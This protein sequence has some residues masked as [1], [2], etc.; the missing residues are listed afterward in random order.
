MGSASHRTALADALGTRGAW[1]DAASVAAPAASIASTFDAPVDTAIAYVAGKLG[2][3]ASFN[4]T[5]SKI[6]TAIDGPL[7]AAPRSISCWF[8]LSDAGNSAIVSYGTNTATNLFQ[9]S[10]AGSTL[11]RVYTGGADI[12]TIAGLSQGPWYHAVVTYDGTTTNLYLDGAPPV[13]SAAA[14]NTTHTDY[15]SVGYG[16]AY[17]ALAGLADDVVM[18]S[19]ALTSGEVADLWNSGAGT[20][21]LTGSLATGLIHHWPL[22]GDSTDL[23]GQAS[24]TIGALNARTSAVCADPNPSRCR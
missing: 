23:L 6:Q 24:L 3:A 1:W 22:D 11:L 4:G 10:V 20:S 18:W 12:I 15:F 5:T 19:R 16:P 8:K 14:I 17:G 9:L 2:Q 21:T 13:S 7:G